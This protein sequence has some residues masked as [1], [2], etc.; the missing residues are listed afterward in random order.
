VVAS[1]CRAGGSI[2]PLPEPAEERA[3]ST[4]LLE[5]DHLIVWGDVERVGHDVE[6]TLG[7]EPADGGVHPGAG[8][9][10]VLFALDGDRFLEVLGPDPEQQTTRAFG[11]EDAGH[12]EGS[13]WWWAART[14]VDLREVVE[15]LGA[16]GV[17][18]DPIRSGSRIRPSGERLAWDMVDPVQDRFGAAL[19]FV[20]RWADAPPVRG[21]G[22]V[23]RQFEL[24]H[25][26]AQAL[27]NAVTALGLDASVDVV[28]GDRP[29]LRAVVQGPNGTLE[30]A[31]P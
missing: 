14:S 17:A 6:R 7:V 1:G 12:P 24:V 22:C 26:D 5:P 28:A 13:L 16:I 10:N 3:T 27:T 15:R 2:P 20:I 19:P 9:R 21:G 11:P 18:T 31:T 8:T 4:P 23:L 29:G 25:P 30:L